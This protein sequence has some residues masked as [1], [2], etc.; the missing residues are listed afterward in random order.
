ML[1]CFCVCIVFALHV[2]YSPSNYAIM[3]C[4]LILSDYFFSLSC[5]LNTVSFR[6]YRVIAITWSIHTSYLVLSMYYN[7]LSHLSNYKIIFTQYYK[8]NYSRPEFLLL[9]LS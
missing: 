3:R 1:L 2:K 4:L 9:S 5:L 6:L 7:I 8:E